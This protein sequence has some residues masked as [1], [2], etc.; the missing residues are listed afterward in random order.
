MSFIQKLFGAILPQRLSEAMEA[1]SRAWRVECSCGFTRSVW[2]LGGI[3]YKASG[4]PRWM[5]VCP[6]CGQRSAHRVYHKP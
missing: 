3:R 1:E 2:E 4:E 5:M 6:Q